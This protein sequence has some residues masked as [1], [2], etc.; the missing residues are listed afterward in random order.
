MSL[1]RWSHSKKDGT[2]QESIQSSTTPGTGYHMGKWQIHIKHHKQESKGQLFPGRWI[3][4]S[5]EQT[6]K[7]DKRKTWITQMIHKR[8]TTLE[9]SVKYFTGGLK[10]VLRR[11]PC[12]W[13]WC[14]PEHLGK[15][16]NT[17]DM[18]AKRSAL[19]QQVTTRLQ[20][21]D[22]TAH[23]RHQHEALLTKTIH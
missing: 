14:G 6:Q 12:P 2:D 13:F 20:G 4:G 10:P 22:M 8:R 1:S 16:Q 21:T 19:S 7:H 11:Q 18:T 9:W 23:N 3:K 15:W 17:T 5:N